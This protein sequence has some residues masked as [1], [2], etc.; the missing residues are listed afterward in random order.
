MC[1]SAGA[2]GCQPGVLGDSEWSPWDD[3][4]RGK[5]ETET[6]AREGVGT[7]LLLCHL[8]I[9]GYLEGGRRT[10]AGRQGEVKE[11]TLPPPMM[12]RGGVWELTSHLCCNICLYLQIS[13][14]QMA[15]QAAEM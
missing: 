2:Q 6:Q 11:G 8:V 12:N 4:A 5:G 9:A 1:E 14:E 13:I 3:E 10:H 7:P 15:Q